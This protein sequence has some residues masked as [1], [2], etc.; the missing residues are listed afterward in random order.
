MLPVVADGLPRVW[1]VPPWQVSTL[2]LLVAA[3]AA[4]LIYV[5]PPLY[6][7][8]LCLVLI[9][10]C[11]YPALCGLRYRLAADEEGVW[12]RRLLSYDV[13]EWAHLAAI[14]VIMPRA[15]TVTIRLVEDDGAQ[16]DVPPSLVLPGRPGSVHTARGHVGRIADELRDIAV[17]QGSPLG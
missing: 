14:R 4:V 8:I 10:G 17:G 3:G 2:I 7:V 11:G 9:A 6:G 1:R 15:G 16:L 12:V 5:Q 13:V